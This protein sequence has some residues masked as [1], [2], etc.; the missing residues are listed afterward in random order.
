MPAFFINFFPTLQTILDVFTWR[1]AVD[2]LI[3][4]ALLHFA[5]VLFKRTNSFFII[6]GIILLFIAYIAA[7][8]LNF[9]LTSLLLQYF[10]GFFI[11]IMVIIFREELRSFF[12]SISFWGRIRR[13]SWSEKKGADGLLDSI[14]KALDYLSHNKIGALLVFPGHQPLDR[15]L[16]GGTLVNG[17][18]STSL[19]I[20]IFDPTSPGHDGAMA[21]EGNRI[22]RFGAHLPLAEKYQKLRNYGT[23]HRAAVGLSEKSDALVFAVSEER[24]TISMARFGTLTELKDAEEAERYM[25]E[26]F[27]E[28]ALFKKASGWVKGFFTNIPEKFLVVGVSL[29]LWFSLVFQLGHVTKEFEIPVEFRFLNASTQI[30][31]ITPPTIQVTLTGKSSDF[32]LF[33]EKNIRVIIDASALELGPQRV[34]VE[35]AM[36][37]VPRGVSIIDFSPNTIRFEVEEKKLSPALPEMQE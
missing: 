5:L 23:R 29:V 34:T 27:D 35:E 21:I 20:S 2:I 14:K 11:L 37:Q 31:K 3:V 9:Y 1:D 6:D 17:E 24:G 15:L 8:F 25:H 28:I 16:Q 10:F 19:I 22:E 12:E 13:P 36:I 18:V 32:E 7:R 26:F 30:T 4:A 33:E